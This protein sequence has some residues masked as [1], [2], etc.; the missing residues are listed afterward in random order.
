MLYAWSL[1]DDLHVVKMHD[2]ASRLGGFLAEGSVR[3]CYIYRDLRDVAASAKRA[4]GHRGDALI[5]VIADSVSHFERLAELRAEFP[6]AVLW[7]RYEDVYGDLRAAIGDTARFLGVSDDSQTV[8]DVHDR[9]SL[10]AAAAISDSA[11]GRLND[12]V[13]RLRERDPKVAAEFLQELRRTGGT[14]TR[15]WRDPDWLLHYNH[16]SRDK[17]APGAWV[18]SLSANEA[19]AIHTAFG[20]WLRSEGYHVAD[21]A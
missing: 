4:L 7:Q 1:D 6:D 12:Y 21:G 3:V 8:E 18:N 5:R 16:I 15:V 19:T 2:V 9:C 10:D 20:D 11:H 14:E 13:A 17:G